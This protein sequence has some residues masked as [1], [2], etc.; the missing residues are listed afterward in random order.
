MNKKIIFKIS[1]KIFIP[2][3][4]A[5]FFTVNL[6]NN[7]ILKAS[8]EKD[9]ILIVDTSLTM[10]GYGT[11]SSN[12]L[13][14][15]KKS[16]PQFIEQL[17]SD[18]SITLITFD[19]DIKIYPTIYIDDKKNKDSLI[20]YIKNI[21]ATGAWTY[22]SQMMKTAF[23]K[24]QEL[25]AKNKKRQQV[26]VIMTDAIDDP[27]PGKR[28]DRL[29]IKQIGKNY[30]DKDWFIFFVNFGEALKSNPQLAKMQKE[31]TADVTKYTKVIETNA[32]QAKKT[33]K[34]TGKTTLYTGEKG[35]QKSIEKDLSENI[36][37]MEDKK[38]GKGGFPYKILIIALL[39]IAIV[40]A[41]LYYFKNYS[42]LRVTGKLEYWDHTMISPYFEKFDLTKQD[43]K[44][45]LVGTKTS[46][47]LTIRDIEITDPFKITAIKVNGEVKN[48]LQ[49]GK[50]YA[51][52]YANRDPEG[53][54]KNG[55]MFKIANYTFKYSET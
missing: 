9:L 10:A 49:A 7:Q 17:D 24:A 37:N 8:N 31:L 16:L 43:A 39:I 21:K 13:P 46:C 20:E 19:T 44:E 26:I 29:N 23:Q 27:P 11:G 47:N 35:I 28:A 32:G 4:T 2:L 54:L 40:L 55:D 48:A 36:K 6:F 18:D 15:V 52:E 42:K 25:E 5:V 41:V 51:I 53:Y 33:D 12:I 3:L 34:M 30:K 14:Q 38:D 22:T 45:I 50:G 1:K